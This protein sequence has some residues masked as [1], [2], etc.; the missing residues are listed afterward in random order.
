MN[1]KLVA[2][3]DASKKAKELRVQLKECKGTLSALEPDVRRFM[4]T[5][6]TDA[7]VINGCTIVK[8]TK[9][10]KKK[11]NKQEIKEI[12]EEKVGIISDQV[13]MMAA[14]SSI[15]LESIALWTRWLDFEVND[16]KTLS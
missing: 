15:V 10:V 6:N 5:E 13:D 12:L 1:E 14:E 4:T 7:M 3:I 16:S 8:Y 9:T 11:P 2:Y